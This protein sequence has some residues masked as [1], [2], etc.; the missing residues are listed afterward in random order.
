[1]QVGD[2]VKYR[3][4]GTYGVITRAWEGKFNKVVKVLYEVLWADGTTS[5]VLPR[6]LEVVC[7]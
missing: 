4:C 7:K 5:D 3:R 2:L 6:R 1:M